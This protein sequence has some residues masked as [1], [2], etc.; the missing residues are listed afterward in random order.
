MTWA[1]QAALIFGKRPIWLYEFTIAGGPPSRFTSALRPYTDDDSVVWTQKNLANTRIR[2]TPTI[3]RSV[4]KLVFARNDAFALTFREDLRNDDN[5]VTIYHE[6][7]GDSPAARQT[8]FIGRVVGVESTLL[9]I[10]LMAEPGFT[11]LRGRG[12]STPLQ[13]NCRHSVYHKTVDHYGCGAA[14]AD[15]QTAEDVTLINDLVLTIPSIS[16]ADPGFYAGGVFEWNGIKQFITDSQGD[17]LTLHRKVPGF[18]TAMA[19]PP[20]SVLLAPGCPG[21]RQICNDRFDR[22]PDHGGFPWADEFQGDGRTM[23]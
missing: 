11:V 20:V 14:L 19:T 8:K 4:V 1:T 10:K 12:A 21:T 5:T 15:F 13:R 22:L 16:G 7:R 18:E 17:Q 6:Y 9:T 23:F 2:R 3:Q